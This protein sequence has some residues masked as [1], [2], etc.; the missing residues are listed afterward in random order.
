MSEQSLKVR[1]VP[2]TIV[3]DKILTIYREGS[4][5]ETELLEYDFNIFYAAAR[6]ITTHLR[7]LE[8][9]PSEWSSMKFV[10]HKGYTELLKHVAS[11]SMLVESNLI[12]VPLPGM[13]FS[14]PFEEEVT[15]ENLNIRYQKA[16]EFNYFIS[17]LEGI[18]PELP[19]SSDIYPAPDYAVFHMQDYEP[20][21]G[22]GEAMYGGHIAIPHAIIAHYNIPSG[23]LPG[24]EILDNLK[25]I[26]I[27]GSKYCSYNTELPWL[28]PLYDILRHVYTEKPHIKLMGIC[29]GTQMLA[30]SLGGEISRNP[31]KDYIYKLET[32]T[33]TEEGRQE[34]PDID[35]I[36]R[37]AES[38]GDCITKLPDSG[39]VYG[40]SESC[41]VELW[42]IPGRVLGIQGHPEFNSHFIL[43]LHSV[44]RFQKGLLN[45]EQ[46]ENIQSVYSKNS[47]D[48]TKLLR[49]IKNFL[50]K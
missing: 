34:F 24:I 42:G 39:K 31:H 5:L 18:N 26:L 21:R 40:R 50:T 47:T 41:E 1:V 23:H 33:L 8:L 10:N 35:D 49:M 38:H 6:V 13:N 17:I 25:G 14:E 29:F 22:L 28:Q 7:L 43:N 9:S 30:R 37:V 32:C 20:W 45:S 16:A 19:L 48:S 36:Y 15:F 12:C 27:T 11:H 2:Y 4:Y 3:S 44:I 46:F